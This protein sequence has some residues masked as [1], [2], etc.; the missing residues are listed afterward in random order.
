[1]GW[2]ESSAGALVGVL[3]VLTVV[4]VVFVALLSD[5]LGSRR[6]Y[7]VGSA[8]AFVLALIG[9]A[10]L[11]AAAWAWVVIGG[12][13]VGSMFPL[14][15]TLP[16]DAE[17]RPGRVGALAGMMLGFGYVVSALAPLGLGAVRDATGSFDSVLWVIAAFGAL[18]LVAVAPL[19]PA[20]LRARQNL[21]NRS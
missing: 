3:N 21:P 17:D 1:M 5:R 15:M 18:F 20:R 13:G 19:S 7:L 10:A 6:P 12:V 4:P 2:S 9:F 8:A 14:V 11:P 16:L